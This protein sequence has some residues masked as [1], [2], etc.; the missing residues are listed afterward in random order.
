[1]KQFIEAFISDEKNSIIPDQFDFWDRFI[2]TWS[3]DRISY[4][5]TNQQIKEEGE[6]IFSRILYGIAM[7]DLFICLYVKQILPYHKSMERPSEYLNQVLKP[8]ISFM[9]V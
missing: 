7:Q 4:S 6:W 9:E 3:F 1:M 5:E 8:G 2:G